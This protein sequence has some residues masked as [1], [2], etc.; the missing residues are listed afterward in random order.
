MQPELRKELDQLKAE[1]LKQIKE[2]EELKVQVEE[3][4]RKAEGSLLQNNKAT[5]QSKP[6]L[7]VKRLLNEM[8]HLRSQLGIL[9][10][11]H[12]SFN[13]SFSLCIIVPL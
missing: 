11:N 4:R 7:D 13:L 1:N 3:M 12:V 10:G 8:D 2:N 5:S 6:E 9:D